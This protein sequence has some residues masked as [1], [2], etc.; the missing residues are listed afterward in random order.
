MWI[1]SSYGTVAD[2]VVRD[3]RR[4]Y[5]TSILKRGTARLPSARASA[6]RRRELPLLQPVPQNL[7]KR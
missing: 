2:G 6:S 1:S 5:T 3:R 4:R 7:L